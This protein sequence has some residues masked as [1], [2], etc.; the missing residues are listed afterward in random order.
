[1]PSS[2]TLP[3]PDSDSLSDKFARNPHRFGMI[4]GFL[5]VPLLWMA[6]DS[7]VSVAL[8]RGV[9]PAETFW[10]YEASGALIGALLGGQCARIW[11][12]WRQGDT[13]QARGIA[14]FTGAL[15]VTVYVAQAALYAG[16]SPYFLADF[17][18]RL[19]SLMLQHHLPFLLCLLLMFCGIFAPRR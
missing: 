13:N 1:M 2:Q 10:S 6:G 4:A 12:Y 7:L 18:W 5:G 16:T 9:L 19:I 11:S 17:G 3:V 14:F 8:G 15:G